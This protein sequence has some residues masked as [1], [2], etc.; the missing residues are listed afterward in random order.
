M[1]GFR[2]DSVEEVAA[3]LKLRPL[4]AHCGRADVLHLVVPSV[5]DEGHE[6]EEEP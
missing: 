5:R 2:L 1:S 6:F 3:Y 4:C